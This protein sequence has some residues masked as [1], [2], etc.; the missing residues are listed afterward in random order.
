MIT[1]NILKLNKNN[2]I[3]NHIKYFFDDSLTKISRFHEIKK[4]YKNKNVSLEQC[5]SDLDSILTDRSKFDKDILFE[6]LTSLIYLSRT[7]YYI[8]SIVNTLKM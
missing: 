1:K 2:L 5:K 8:N 3:L 6:S 4:I 7:D